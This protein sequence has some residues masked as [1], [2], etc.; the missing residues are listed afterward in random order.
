MGSIWNSSSPD[1]IQEGPGSFVF[2]IHVISWSLEQSIL[3]SHVC[4]A[5]FLGYGTDLAFPC[6]LERSNTLL[7]PS[8]FSMCILRNLDPPPF[9]SFSCSFLFNISYYTNSTQGQGNNLP[10]HL[11]YSVQFYMCPYL[12]SSHDR[13]DSSFRPWA[14][15]SAKHFGL[16]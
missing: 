3:P 11:Y 6:C 13:S 4:H 8:A 9:S 7:P 5:R 12:F 14:R 2:A 10:L 15:G 1:R 16:A